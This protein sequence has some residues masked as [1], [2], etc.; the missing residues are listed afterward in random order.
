M[1]FTL[2]KEISGLFGD[3]EN[4]IADLNMYN[5]NV[6][7]DNILRYINSKKNDKYKNVL[8]D[9]LE[10][11]KLS[12]VVFKDVEYFMDLASVAYSQINT[13]NLS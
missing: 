1:K 3:A 2:G 5:F 7:A 4:A 10:R 6:A 8:K 9:R 12:M 13:Y 11:L